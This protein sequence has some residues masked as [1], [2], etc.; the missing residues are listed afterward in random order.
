MSITLFGSCRIARICNN[1]NLNEEISYTHNTKEVIQLIK[2]LK[3]E[4]EIQFP[5]NMLCFRTGITK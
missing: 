4:L 3:G 1:N 2:F 5:Y